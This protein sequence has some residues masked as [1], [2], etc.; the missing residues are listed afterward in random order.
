MN[1]RKPWMLIFVPFA[2]V[3]F[4]GIGGLIVSWLWNAILPGLFGLPTI[5]FWQALGILALS[6]ILFGDF[7]SGSSGKRR[8]NRMDRRWKRRHRGGWQGH[9]SPEERE[10]I[11]Q[12]LDMQPTE[13]AEAE[14][15]Q[16]DAETDES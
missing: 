8:M 4:L 3:F 16:A 1:M 10:R 13:E 9:F 11:R 15:E 6:R 7:G 5:T 12:H 14:D 2:I